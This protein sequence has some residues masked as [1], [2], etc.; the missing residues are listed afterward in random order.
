MVNQLIYFYNKQLLP[1]ARNM[2]FTWGRRQPGPANLPPLPDIGHFLWQALAQPL[3][4]PA[5]VQRPAPGRVAIAVPD[6]GRP[7]PVATLLL[8]LL[9]DLLVSLPFLTPPKVSIG[10]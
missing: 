5:P 2:L 9:Q 4:C 10:E 1:L 6:E 8:L 3:G 7:V